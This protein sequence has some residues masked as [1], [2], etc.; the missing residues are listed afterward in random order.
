MPERRCLPPLQQQT[1]YRRLQGYPVLPSAQIRGMSLQVLL[2]TPL[3]SK[4]PC[5]TKSVLMNI[6]RPTSSRPHK[7][8]KKNRPSQQTSGTKSTISSGSNQSLRP[9]GPSCP[10]ETA[11]PMRRGVKSSLGAPV[12]AR[13]RSSRPSASQVE[14]EK[15]IEER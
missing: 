9:I 1:H 13:H 11:F 4:C 12:G 5:L 3:P 2:S 14:S 7:L 10:R 15:W 6:N 8:P